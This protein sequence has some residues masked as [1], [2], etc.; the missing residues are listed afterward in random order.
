MI[1]TFACKETEKIWNRQFS[2]KFPADIQ[3][4]SAKP[5]ARRKLTMIDAT[6]SI[7]DLAIPPAN[8]LKECCGKEKRDK[9]SIRINN[10][11]RICF[12]FRVG[13]P[14]RSK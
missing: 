5:I 13:M 3:G 11:W 6:S 2:K 12:Y 9:F 8:Q 4:G 14:L 1:K 10:Q 7:D